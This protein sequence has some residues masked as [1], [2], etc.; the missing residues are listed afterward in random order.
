[1]KVIDLERLRIN[2]FK[3]VVEQDITFDGDTNIFGANESG[4]STEYTAFVWLLTGKD[5]FDRSDYAI[6]NT[7]RKELNTHAHEVEGVLKVD[8]RRVT[9]KRAYYEEWVR[10]TGEAQ[11]VF[12]GH[13]TEYWVNDAKIS[14]TGYQAAVD[15]IIAPKIIKLITNP[16][17]F[18]SLNWE[19]QRSGLL[20]IAGE[21]TDNDIFD[22]I[23]TPEK[24]YSNLINEFNNGETAEKLKASLAAK[25][26]KLKK[27]AVEFGPRIDEVKRGLTLLET[28][29]W[30][31]LEKAI[32]EKSATIA[33]IDEALT[34]ASK[35]LSLKQKGV[36]A[37]Q[38]ELH[39][40]QTALSSI[41]QNVKSGYLAKQNNGTGEI[42]SLENQIATL[43][44]TIEQLKKTRTDNAT[45]KESYLSRIETKNAIVLECREAWSVINAEKFE[46]DDS[47]CE[48]PT[49][50][51]RLPEDDIEAQKET[52]RANFNKSV[53][54]RKQAQVDK[55][56]QA[57]TEIKQL[58]E[59]IQAIDSINI[60]EN[61]NAE[62]SKL[63]GL[64]IQLEGLKTTEK[65]KP[66]IDV[67]VAVD[68][69]MKL[70]ADALNLVDEIAALN[71]SITSETDLLNQDNNTDAEKEQKKA[72]EAEI[73]ELN[74]KLAVREAIENTND[75][76]SQL[77][78]EENA[79]AQ[80]IADLEQQEFDLQNY[81]RARMD[82][83][84]SRVN[85]MFNYVKFRMFKQL[86]N[87]S[88]E[89][90]CVCEYNG[91]PYP[92][93]NTAG[94]LLAGLDIIDTLQKFYGVRAPVLC[95][96]RESA[97][98]IP[99]IKTQIISLYVSEKDK[100]LRIE[101]AVKDKPKKVAQELFE[102]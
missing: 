39:S 27:L 9:L 52:M 88:I 62:E 96:N 93:L 29:N 50:K 3:G 67:E 45:N 98:W 58:E 4:K 33:E 15:E 75:R 55:S 60:T 84:E 11:K 86:V 24:D 10:P 34:S 89:E 35:A 28:H 63:V 94:K 72:L 66:V 77:I 56:N 83:L 54:D 2:N 49:C 59:N 21:I 71:T 90:T 31:L 25:K 70:N 74:K 40:K 99:P 69:L 18:N 64:N 47:K 73:K 6:K 95:D 76:L 8:S 1:M 51:Q 82:I 65:Q 30:P 79:N 19:V 20:S 26:L 38:N 32:V 37:K 13:K 48:C 80:A 22:A 23:S 5:E 101:K 36:M 42:A 68:A 12:K 44:R 92:T 97:T 7:V 57:K 17:Y 16:Y 85:G 41:R 100:V 78:N 87:G 81:T 14:A 46:F 53:I 43:K 61:I 91:V 102:A